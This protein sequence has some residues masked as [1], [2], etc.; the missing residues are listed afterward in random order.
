M[1]FFSAG[2]SHFNDLYIQY[3]FNRS[4]ERLQDDPPKF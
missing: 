2:F 1:D 3:I 4:I